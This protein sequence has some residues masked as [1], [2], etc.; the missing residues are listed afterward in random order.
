MVT[1]VIGKGSKSAGIVWVEIE[2]W[3]I[4]CSAIWSGWINIFCST[5]SSLN[6]QGI[7]RTQSPTNKNDALELPTFGVIVGVSLTG[8][9]WK[10][11]TLEEPPSWSWLTSVP[12]KY[13]LHLDFLFNRHRN[14]YLDYWH[15]FISFNKSVFTFKSNPAH[16]VYL[17]NLTESA[18]L[19]YICS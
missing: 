16:S 2:L 17:Q 15:T 19:W 12:G 6:D 5:V 10:G 11:L 8:V 14:I 3:F 7:A 18:I 9:Q 4:Q 13:A 1:L